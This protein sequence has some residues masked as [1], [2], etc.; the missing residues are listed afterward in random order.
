MKTGNG[1]N[2][3]G[4][5]GRRMTQAEELLERELTCSI[6]TDLLFDP[7]TLLSCLHTN[8]GSCAKKWFS[9]SSS[10]TS[11]PCATPKLQSCPVCRKRVRGWTQSSLVAS[12]LDGFLALHPERRRTQEEVRVLREVWAPGMELLEDGRSEDNKEDGEA[13]RRRMQMVVYQRARPPSR[14]ISTSPISPSF[15]PRR[16]AS[17]STPSTPRPSS[18]SLPPIQRRISRTPSPRDPPDPEAPPL[19]PPTSVLEILHRGINPIIITCDSCS[20]RLDNSV[21]HECA[22]CPLFHLCLRCSRTTPHP[23][24]LHRQKLN[25]IWPRRNLITGIF[26]DVCDAWCDEDRNEKSRLGSAFFHCQ[27]CNGGNWAYCLRCVQRG[28]SCTHELVLWSNDRRRDVLESPLLKGNPAA[29]PTIPMLRRLG[30]RPWEPINPSS[31]SS[32]SSSSSTTTSTTTISTPSPSPPTPPP[33]TPSQSCTLCHLPIP[34]TSTHLHCFLCP[35]SSPALCTTCYYNLHRTFPDHN[36]ALHRFL[37]C[38]RGHA[39]AVLVAPGREVRHRAVGAVVCRPRLPEWVAGRGRRA[40]AVRA[41]WMEEGNQAGGIRM[42]REGEV[43]RSAMG[44]GGDGLGQRAWG[45]GQW[46][47]FP[48]GAEVW[49][50]VRVFGREGDDPGAAVE[51]GGGGSAQNGEYGDRQEYEHEQGDS[52]AAV[53]GGGWCWGSFAGTV[54]LFPEECVRFV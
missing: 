24:P 43:E 23:H 18:P 39:L 15:H 45:F 28:W 47:C 40:V 20:T 6:C 10:S 53:G 5:E 36:R 32:S 13:G 4:G 8:C 49:D 29:I 46:L 17:T 34:P 3:N 27:S 26:C 50:V 35:D 21:H 7:I 54:G 42:G 30:Y 44:G 16:R 1:G 52:Q 25:S 31:T 22:I 19:P 14:T 11:I 12:L 48:V 41:C 37:E 2:G 9:R 51:V 33:P 38:A